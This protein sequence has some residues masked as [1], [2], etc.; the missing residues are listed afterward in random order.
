MTR[1]LDIL[2]V[3]PGGRKRIYQGLADDLTAIQPPVWCELLAS[4]VRRH[5]F[6]AQILDTDAGELEPEDA[7]RCVDIIDPKCVAIVCYG[8]QPSASTQVMPGALALSDAIKQRSPKLPVILVG[9]HVAALHD[10]TLAESSCD[11]VCTGEGFHTLVEFCHYVNGR[12]KIE[13]VRGLVMRG[14]HEGRVIGFLET[15]SPPLLTDLTWVGGMPSLYERD[16]KLDH[17][18]C[19]NWHGWTGQSRSPYAT[20]YTSL[21]CPFKCSFCCIQAP[22]KSGEKV[23]K[24]PLANSYR[25][26]DP[27]VVVSWIDNLVVRYGVKNIKIA[28]EMFVL[29]K[30]HVT[31]LCDELATRK[32]DLNMWAYARVDTC[33][34][35]ALLSKMR[36]VGFRWL[37]IGIESASEGVRD[38]VDKS[39]GTEEMHQALRRITNAGIEIGAN[40]I[41]GLPDDDERS[42]R[43]TLELAKELNTSWANF[44]C[45]MAYPGSALYKTTPKT[46]LPASWSAYSQHSVD[47]YPLRT[48]HLTAERVLEFRDQAFNEYFGSRRYQSAIQA[49]FGR[50]DEVQRMLLQKLP[51]AL[52]SR[53]ARGL[54]VCAPVPEGAAASS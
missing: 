51:R 23:S 30:H 39:F 2:L 54:G 4:Y 18:R 13:D 44:Y 47:T 33:N 6:G 46:D 11:Y 31:E 1:Q 34:D 45:A 20:F 8:N 24:S 19:H 7:A 38:G 16:G 43:D 36:S 40:Y 29:N 15:K 5:S 25:R 53:E 50:Q 26:W 49:K 41:F 17:Y 42:M 10:E 22:F 21:G 14:L 35:E 28:D 48:K 32:Y 52:H 27:K 12:C 9:G 37:G 3:H